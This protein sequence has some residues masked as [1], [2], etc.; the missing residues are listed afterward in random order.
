MLNNQAA[1]NFLQAGV[2][3]AALVLPVCNGFAADLNNGAPPD[4]SDPVNQRVDK[5][6]EFTFAPYFV[7]ANIV[8]TSQVGRLPATDV[9]VNAQNILENLH[10]GAMFRSEVMYRQKAGVLVDVAYMKLG[11]ATDILRTGGRARVGVS[12]LILET[13]ATYRA[14]STERS[15]VDVLAGSRY[16][17]IGL[18]LNVTGSI[19]GNATIDRGDS[20][21]DPVIGLRGAYALNDK[22]SVLGRADVG[23]FGVGSDF[24]WNVQAGT[25]YSLNDTWSLHLQYKALSVDYDNGKTGTPSFEYDTLTHGPLVGI[26]ATF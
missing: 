21:I 15:Y 11:A 24:S 6:W 26:S 18:D 4:R 14:Y 16:W 20:W 19:I 8:G 25:A 10:F 22:W 23:G 3:G 13:M 7:G 17:D 1:K 9:D 12:Q 2:L 5:A